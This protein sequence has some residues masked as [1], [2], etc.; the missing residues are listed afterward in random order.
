MAPHTIP[1]AVGDVCRCKEKTGLRRSPRVK[2]PR[3]RHH[4]KWSYRWMGVKGSTSNGHRDPKCPSARRFG[5]VRED[6]R[7]FSEGATC[8][9]MVADEAIGCTCEGA[10][11]YFS[12]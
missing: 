9:W 11:P 3:G 6:T 12:Y 5:M 7:A 8:A 4:S 1:P 10:L 2:F